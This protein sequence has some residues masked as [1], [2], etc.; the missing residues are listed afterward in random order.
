MQTGAG[1]YI[2]A[3]G[4]WGPLGWSE[5]S[6]DIKESPRRD[7]TVKSHPWRRENIAPAELETTKTAA[8]VVWGRASGPS[9]GAEPRHHTISST[10]PHRYAVSRCR[11]IGRSPPCSANLT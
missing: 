6:K 5:P 7:A 2:G 9:N 3:T 11:C 4:F 10:C 1:G 8:V